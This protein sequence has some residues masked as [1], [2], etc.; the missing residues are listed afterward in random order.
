M[1]TPSKKKNSKTP[2]FLTLSTPSPS[3]TLKLFTSKSIS[4]K[5]SPS[6]IFH[7]RLSHHEVPLTDKK[8]SR[9][10]QDSS[11]IFPNSI[12]NMFPTHLE[13]IERIRKIKNLNS[14]MPFSPKIPPPDLR[15]FLISVWKKKHFT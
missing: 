2:Q 7:K 12:E 6:K 4:S 13:V 5:K 8:F 3:K 9:T 15:N 11:E 14:P 10:K 1:S